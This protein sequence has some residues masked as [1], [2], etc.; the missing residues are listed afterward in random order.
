VKANVEATLDATTSTTKTENFNVTCFNPNDNSV[1]SN[2]QDADP[3]S[4][5]KLAHSDTTTV[6]TRLVD[7]DLVAYKQGSGNVYVDY[8]IY[9]KSVTRSDG[10][11]YTFNPPIPTSVWAADASRFKN[12]TDSSNTWTTTA[13]GTASLTVHVTATKI[14]QDAHTVTVQFT[15]DIDQGAGNYAVY[16][17]FPMA[18]QSTYVINTDQQSVQSISTVSFHGSS[19]SHCDQNT[20]TDMN[21]TACDMTTAGKT[22]PLGCTFGQQ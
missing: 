18:H 19:S 9:S 11:S 3:N 6:F 21:F 13:T 20:H 10:L 14:G 5:D 15:V 12:T 1:S 17:N 4:P 2:C 8:L 22:T 7:A 16:A